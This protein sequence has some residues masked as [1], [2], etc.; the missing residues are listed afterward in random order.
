MK[1]FTIILISLTLVFSLCG[2]GALIDNSNSNDPDEPSVHHDVSIGGDCN[3]ECSDEN[4]C[5]ADPDT[6]KDNKESISQNAVP[7]SSDSTGKTPSKNVVRKDVADPVEYKTFSGDTMK[8]N[9]GATNQSVQYEYTAVR[10]GIYSMQF[11]ADN[12]SFRIGFSVKDQKGHEIVSKK[13][14]DEEYATFRLDKGNRYYFAVKN[15]SSTGGHYQIQL[16]VPDETQRADNRIEGSMRYR[17]EEDV[18]VFTSGEAGVYGF[19]TTMPMLGVWMSIIDPKG[20]TV[21]NSLMQDGSETTAKLDANTEYTICFTYY[22][23]PGE[24]EMDICPQNPRREIARSVTDSIRFV[25]EVDNY[26]FHANESRTYTISASTPSSPALYITIYDET[27]RQVQCGYISPT[28]NAELEN[29]HNY[30]ISVTS[31]SLKDYN[32]TLTID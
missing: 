2:C 32:Y 5:E 29:G 26:L 28:L 1:R 18:Y 21:Y 20:K 24:Y 19:R 31:P 9:I 10:S 30:L 27:G 8:G 25:D 16:N 15:D 12:V 7:S 14:S 17:D 6:E 22:S 4:G 23:N 11:V 13:L 3:D